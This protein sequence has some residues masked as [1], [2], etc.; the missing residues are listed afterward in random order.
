M[1][2]RSPIVV[3]GM[4]RSG[5][6]LV[7]AILSQLGVFFG[8]DEDLVQP[9]PLDPDGWFERQALSDFNRR[10]LSVFQMH[11]TSVAEMPRTWRSH[12]LAEGL[13]D[14][15]ERLLAGIGSDD[16]TWGI[17]GSMICLLLPLYREVFR[18]LGLSPR[19]LLCVRNP[20]DLARLPLKWNH[21]PDGHW[22]PPLGE[23]GIGVWLRH[24][25]DALKEEDVEV[26]VYGQ[27]LE[28]PQSLIHRVL[29]RHADA[30][31][32]LT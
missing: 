30:L 2:E 28:D 9:E 27:M 16:R 22:V 5:G 32:G 31:S 20:S 13:C 6:S 15:L 23:P 17:E 7:A 18:R 21:G 14:E 12:P 10:G 29:C 11:V 24:N 1:N 26:L 19:H 4:P 8:R 3:L 25:V